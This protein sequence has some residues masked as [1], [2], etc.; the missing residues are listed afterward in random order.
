MRLLALPSLLLAFAGCIADSA[1]PAED[2]RCEDGKCDDGDVTA[3]GY[4]ADFA[5]LNARYPGTRRMEK[6]EDAYTIRI[7]LGEHN[8]DAPTH[9]FGAAVNV[10]PYSNTDGQADASG[11]ILERGDQVIAKYFPAGTV[12]FEIKHH[13]P[14]FRDLSL[15]TAGPEMKEH[16]KLQDT[17]IGIVVGV[18][19]DGKPGAITLNNPQTYEG[20]AFGDEKYGMIFVRPRYPAS[21]SAEQVKLAN[22]N[23]RLMV[24]GFNAVSNFPGDYNGGDPLAARNPAQL[25]EHVI[26]MVKAIAGDADAR[27]WF[28]KD[29]NLIYCAELA[30][31]AASGGVLWPL[32]EATM[33]PLVGDAAWQAFAQAIE[34]HNAGRPSAFTQLNRNP[35]VAL[36]KL[37]RPSE[38]AT[39]R[40]AS[41]GDALAFRPMTMSDIVEHFMRT[42]IPR[43]QL[44]E[45][46]A[47]LQGAVLAQMKPGLLEAMAIDKLPANDPIRVAVEALFGQIVQ[48]VSMPHAD[49]NAFRRAIDPL[50]AQ[51]RQMTGPRADNGVGLFVP[52]SLFHVVA[53]GKHT[54]GLLGLRVVGHGLHVS[55]VRPK[56]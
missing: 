45:S 21:M 12:G 46:V 16:F 13:R 2:S 1:D 6:I 42:H 31:V 22:D 33:K 7:K 23:M 18:E 47:P 55:V 24:V 3:S 35:R 30:H 40:P 36:V 38:L 14:E 44:G 27:A 10:I 37:P 17:H 49:Y 52:P 39:L 34:D 20:G 43:E 29:E 56:E 25:R 5:K 4:V 26:Q 9:L 8:V 11:A 54:G 41:S 51:A 48:V 15:E 28:T 19:R 50:L 32:N 53:Q